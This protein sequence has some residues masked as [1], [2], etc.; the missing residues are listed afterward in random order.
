MQIYPQKLKDMGR[1]RPW[2]ERVLR[3]A[4]MQPVDLHGALAAAL[5]ARDSPVT[6]ECADEST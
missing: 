3:W 4:R 1:R 2:T 5:K 6:H